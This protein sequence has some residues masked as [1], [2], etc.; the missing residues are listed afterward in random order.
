MR[1]T[2][3][4]EDAPFRHPVTK[5]P[6]GQMEVFIGEM[7]IQEVLS[8]TSR[9]YIISGDVHEGDIVRISEIKI[10]LVF[11]Q[12]DAIDWYLADSYYR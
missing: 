4:R 7:E 3:L 11:I 2:I 6:L 10:D 12:S 8:D 1:F 9:G 5:E